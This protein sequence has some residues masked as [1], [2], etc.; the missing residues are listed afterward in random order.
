MEKKTLVL[1]SLS[2]TVVLA[3]P[4]FPP[5]EGQ[6]PVLAKEEQRP[7][8]G[9]W[10]PLQGH[11]EVE[12]PGPQ[13]KPREQQEQ[14]APGSLDMEKLKGVVELEVKVK[15]GVKVEKELKA[16][17]E[18]KPDVKVEQELKAEP[19]VKPDVKVEQELKAEPEVKPDVKVEQELKAEPVIE[20]ETEPAEKPVFNGE[21]EVQEEFPVLM[22][23][24][25]ERDVGQEVQERHIDMERTY[26][27]AGDT[28]MEPE[29]QNAD[30]LEEE[31]SDTRLS[32]MEKTL[33]AAFQNEGPGDESLMMEEGN[34]ADEEPVINLEPLL[35]DELIPETAPMDEWPALDS[36]GDP[37]LPFDEYYPNGNARMERE[38][39][40]VLAIEGMEPGSEGSRMADMSLF[41]EKVLEDEPMFD[42]DA[43]MATRR[44]YCRGVMLEGKCYQFFRGPLKAEDAEFFCQSQFPGG[45]L[46][47]ITS[48]HIH[49]ELMNMML[50]QNGYYTRTWIGGLRYLKTGRF[51]WLDGS[52]WVYED[53]LA[54]EPNHTSQ[55][56]D[57]V[58]VLALGNGKFNDFTCWEPQAFICSFRVQ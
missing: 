26:E 56:E 18:V 41:R 34:T 13:A 31:V 30:I 58:E 37:I 23:P 19:E 47:S 36:M 4:P 8:V 1:L 54:G 17:P 20:V 3:M 29:P 6:S 48:Q 42:G 53:W 33:K 16:E 43:Q 24:G 40:D 35:N 27:M 38:Q 51:I 14:M 15:P 12:H 5:P 32:D 25:S 11:V 46:A 7:V 49:R 55:L 22:N 44:S 28:V 39:Q 9:D 21:Q 50:Q 2:L 52:Q 45:H 10:V 57:C